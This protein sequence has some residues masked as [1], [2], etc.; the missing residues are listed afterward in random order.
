[1]N[2]HR[3]SGLTVDQAQ[4][5]V[6]RELSTPTRVR[7]LVFFMLT[8]TAAALLTMLWLTEPEPLPLRTHVAFGILVA[9]N[10]AWSA[11]SGWVILRRRVLFAM[12]RVIAGW[13]AIAFC[14]IFVAAGLAIGLMR[15]N[16]IALIAVGLLGTVQLVV[17]IRMLRQAQ[18]RRSALLS[19]RDEL[20]RMLASRN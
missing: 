12:H 5:I 18:Y 1:M 13:M 2:T 14:G 20:T 3:A 19:R 16:A 4:D 8:M 17:A 9:I 7:Y 6:R 15:T 10:L 11:L